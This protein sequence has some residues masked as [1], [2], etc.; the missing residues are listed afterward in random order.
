MQELDEI[1]LR[2]A[3]HHDH[4]AFKALYNLYAPFLWRVIYRMAPGDQLVAR[5]LLQ[6]TF[7][8]IHHALH[9]FRGDAALS[10]WLYRIAYTTVLKRRRHQ[11]I[12]KR[13]V[14]CTDQVAGTESADQFD[15]RQLTDQILSALAAEDRFLLVAREVDDLSFEE[16][17]A[18]T[19]KN[20]GALR[21]QLH[22]LKE[23]IRQTF[24]KEDMPLECETPYEA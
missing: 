8:N 7:V 13:N 18:I 14:P 4:N 6:D 19:G 15:N 2:K 1:T 22:R 11:T 20:S 17:A 5:E 24:V 3:I 21:T 12:E 16:I 23:R 9:H 10:T